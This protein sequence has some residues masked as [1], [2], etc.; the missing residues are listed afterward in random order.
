[1]K[2]IEKSETEPSLVDLVQKWLERTPGLETEGFDFWGKYQSAVQ[3]LLKEQEKSVDVGNG[4]EY[5]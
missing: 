5:H 2:L 3:N 1:M 4:R